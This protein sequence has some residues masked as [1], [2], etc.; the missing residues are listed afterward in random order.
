MSPISR[1]FGRRLSRALGPLFPPI[2]FLYLL[3]NERKSARF[4]PRWIRSF[5]LSRDSVR[6]GLPWLPFELIEWLDG[7]LKK[8][9]TVFEFG[10]GGSTI[11]MAQRVKS[12]TSVEHDRVWHGTVLAELK[13]RGLDNVKYLLREP[14]SARENPPEEYWDNYGNDYAGMSFAPYVTAIDEYPDHFFDLVLVD[15]RSRKFCLEH[16]ITKTRPGGFIVMDNSSTQEYLEFYS[17]LEKFPRCD[18]TGI[19]PFWP[20][21]KWQ[22]TRWQ[23]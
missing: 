6:N 7:Y 13:K 3:L 23:I 1:A 21:A 18:I 20:P 2:H 17:P 4:F 8:E 9:R 11:F 22:A 14:V 19:A 5:N 12:L 10:S 16:A 15:G